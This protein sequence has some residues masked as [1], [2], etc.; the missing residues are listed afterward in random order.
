MA[1]TFYVGRSVRSSEIEE[2]F[3][4]YNFFIPTEVE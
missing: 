2:K 4:F 3:E 1:F